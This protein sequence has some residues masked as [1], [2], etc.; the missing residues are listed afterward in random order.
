ML[1]SLLNTW[2]VDI[3]T[4]TSTCQSLLYSSALQIRK[5]WATEASKTPILEFN[6]E[7][8]M[9]GMGL[10]YEQFVDVCIL[11][12]CDYCETIKGIAATSAYKLIKTHGTIA[13]VIESLDKTKHPVSDAIDYDEVRDLFLHALITPPEEV[14]IKWSDPDEAGIIKFLV[15]EKVKMRLAIKAEGNRSR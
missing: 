6:L 12:G 7:K 2:N 8:A 15:E 1:G 10:T 5:L 3:C 11:A 13:K 14:E 9:S 4:T